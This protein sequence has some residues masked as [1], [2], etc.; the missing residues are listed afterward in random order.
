MSDVINFESVSDI[1][2]LAGYDVSPEILATW[3]N[4]KVKR[5]E[6][7]AALS[8]LRASDNDDIKLPKFPEYL[9]GFEIHTWGI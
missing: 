6:K 3:S 2:G 4:H 1:L 5:A 9:K 8:H 7:W